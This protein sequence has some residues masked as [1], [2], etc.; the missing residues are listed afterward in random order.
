ME[1][2]MTRGNNAIRRELPADRRWRCEERRQQNN[3]PDKRYGRPW[4][5]KRQ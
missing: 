2:G 3:K 1:R 5:N 4:H